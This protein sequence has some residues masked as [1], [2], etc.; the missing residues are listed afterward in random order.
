MRLRDKTSKSLC[1]E[2]R[3]MN[4]VMCVDRPWGVRRDERMSLSHR[5]KF[6][7]GS[8]GSR[9]SVVLSVPDKVQAILNFNSSFP[10]S[11][12]AYCNVYTTSTCLKSFASFARC[13]VYMQSLLMMFLVHYEPHP[14]C[15]K[16]VALTRSCSAYIVYTSP[17]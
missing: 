5:P 12:S 6:Y 16:V 3:L 1:A 11:V 4:D 10:F 14:V 8:A 13:D 15:A 7:L 9:L 2:L 17:Q